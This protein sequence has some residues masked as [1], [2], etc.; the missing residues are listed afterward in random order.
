MLKDVLAIKDDTFI[1][2]GDMLEMYIPEK[3][4]ETGI[5]T[6]VGS[7]I[8]L[9]IGLFPVRGYKGDKVIF[10]ET[11]NIP[12]SFSITPSAIKKVDSDIRNNGMEKFRVAVFFKDAPVMPVY[13]ERNSSNCEAFLNMVLLGKIV[14]VPY[15]KLM[16]IWLKN[17]S[18]NGVGLNVPASI[19]EMI[20]TQIYRSSDN[21]DIT[22]AQAKNKNPEL[23]E[24]A[25]TT[26]NVR[27]ICSK[28]SVFASLS[29]EDFDRMITS[30]LNMTKEEK[31]Q[32]TSPLE[33][34]IKY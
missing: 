15:S 25:Y 2:K 3:F 11:L 19:M 12:S 33:K 21:P 14:G 31:D 9:T 13:L 7:S 22:Y 26:A 28:S 17:L 4:F 20:L 18:I 6:F 27:D 1:H 16:D 24:Y 10:T 23:S 8:K 32:Q 30:S 34:I 5:A 29:F